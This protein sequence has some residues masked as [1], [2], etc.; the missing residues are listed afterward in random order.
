MSEFIPVGAA[1]GHSGGKGGGNSLSLQPCQDHRGLRGQWGAF[2][3]KIYLFYLFIFGC[4]G[5]S[6]GCAGFS[7]RWLLLLQSTG[8][9][10]ADFSS[11]GSLALERGLGSCGERA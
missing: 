11:C 10:H 1:G 5:S 2:F 7:L 9:R 4:I 6:L 3:F 8:C